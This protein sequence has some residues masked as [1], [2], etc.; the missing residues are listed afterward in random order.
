MNPKCHIDFRN[1]LICPWMPSDF[2]ECNQKFSLPQAVITLPKPKVAS[3]NRP[4]A[5]QLEC[6]HLSGTP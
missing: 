4:N 5:G 6:L 3:S 1:S 2:S